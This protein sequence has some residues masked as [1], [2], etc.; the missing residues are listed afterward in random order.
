MT[1]GG[2]SCKLLAM[3]TLRS[4]STAVLLCLALAAPASA[5][6]VNL[7]L[8]PT[9]TTLGGSPVMATLTGNSQA[10]H[11]THLLAVANTAKSGSCEGYQGRT[12]LE[13]Q[14]EPSSKVNVTVEIP[15]ADYTVIGTYRVCSF[16]RAEPS[17][18]SPYESGI[19]TVLAVP[20]PAPPAPVITPAPAPVV[21]P[22]AP[23]VKPLTSA[24][25]LHTALAK[26]KRQ[27]N[28]RKR[29]KCERQARKAARHR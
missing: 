9:T 27:K 25:K 22:P 12:I 14:E 10:P 20:P 6:E 29:A 21:T 3:K 2:K 28:K 15:P 5:A 23:V 24:Q 8:S 16:V 4:I 19:F 13:V 7:S 26:C 11:N 18:H 1:S 17:E